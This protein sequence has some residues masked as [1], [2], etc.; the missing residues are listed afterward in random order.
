MASAHLPFGGSSSSPRGLVPSLLSR[1]IVTSYS[2]W[3]EVGSLGSDLRCGFGE[4]CC[5]FFVEDL[6]SREATGDIVGLS[7]G[8]HGGRVGC[9]VTGGRNQHMRAYCGVT[10]TGILPEGGFDSLYRM[11]V[12]VLPEEQAAHHGQ[13]P[14]NVSP[15]IEVAGDQFP[16]CVYFLPFVQQR[17][18]IRQ[19]VFWRRFQNFGLW[20]T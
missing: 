5:S 4:R 16:R 19:Q 3:L 9:Q 6:T 11:E 8:T 12:A 2:L 18:K 13:E 14:V 15:A 20:H 10:Q 1:L 7:L 17:P